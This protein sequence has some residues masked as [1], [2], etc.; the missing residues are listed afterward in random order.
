[1]SNHDIPCEICGEDTRG[2]GAHEERSHS[3]GDVEAAIRSVIR[4]WP[5]S[6]YKERKL[7]TLRAILSNMK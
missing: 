4:T 6:E 2:L 7:R 3:K 1:M 5:S